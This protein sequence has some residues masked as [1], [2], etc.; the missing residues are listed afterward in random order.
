MKPR[1]F[2]SYRK[3]STLKKS[4]YLLVIATLLLSIFNPFV[5]LIENTHAASKNS[6][7]DILSSLSDE[8]RKA[9]RNLEATQNEGL[10]GFEPRDL[11]VEEDTTVIVEFQSK[12]E[13]ISRLT[14]ALKGVDI[15]TK[16][17]KEK[18]Q[19]E[20][21]EFE[22]YAKKNNIKIEKTYQ[23][24]F[25]G[26]AVTLPAD[27]IESLLE[28]DGVK[29]IY[30]NNTFSIE[31]EQENDQESYTPHMAD[32]IPFLSIDRL[33]EEGITGKGVK[34][35]VIDTGIDYH[36]P[37]LKD[38]F[39]GGYD[40]IDND[41]DPME[42]TYEDWKESG[43]PLVNNFNFYYT[44]HGTHVAGTIAA[45]GK[46]TGGVTVKGVA[47]DVQLYGYRVLGP[48][49]SG[50]S[51]DIIAGIDRAVSDGM[52]VIN[53]SL[54][55][56]VNEPFDPTSIAINNAVLSGVV[57][58]VS[59]GNTG[60]K[61]YSLGTP[62][63]AAYALTVG[64]SS[65]SLPIVYFTA[66]GEKDVS[67]ELQEYA[68]DFVTDL[69]SFENQSFDIVDLGNG[70]RSD[71][72]GKN[73]EGKV[74]LVNHGVIGTQDKIVYA[75]EHGAIAVLIYHND[76][77]I[78]EISSFAGE[79]HRFIPSFYMNNQ[80]GLE[81]KDLLHSGEAKLKFS[82]YTVSYTKE[83]ELAE[84]S[85]RGPSREN[86]DIK[87]EV[88]AP[89]VSILSTVPAYSV[90][91]AASSDYR[92]AYDRYS[93]TSMAAPHV[94]GM[95]ALMLQNNPDL[96][97]ADIKTLLMN[98]SVPLKG[99]YSVFDIGAGRIS[100]YEAIH[101]EVEL[102]VMDKTPMI[103]NG[104]KVELDEVTGSL[105]FGSYFPGEGNVRTQ[106]S[107]TIE[108]KGKKK[109]QFD[110]SVEFTESSLDAK[111]GVQVIVKDKVHVK[112][113][114]QTKTNVSLIVP[115][116]AEIGMYEGYITFEN[117]LDQEE[118]YRIPF[119]FRTMENGFHFTELSSP[120]ISPP[121]VHVK[122]NYYAK[123]WVDLQFS[124][125]SPMK[126][127]DFVL[128]EGNTGQDLGYLGSLNL[129]SAYDG[130]NYQVSNVFNGEYYPFTNEEEQPIASKTTKAKPG[131]Y[132]IKAIGTSKQDLVFTQEMNV[133]IDPKSPS[134]WSELD[135]NA[136]PVIEYPANQEEYTFAVKV[137]DS[138]IDQM[139]SAGMNVDQTLNT[140]NY[141][142]NNNYNP[143]IPVANDGSLNLN[144][145]LDVNKPFISYAIFA[146]D[147]ANN[148]SEKKTY[149]FIKEGMPYGYMDSDATTVNMGDT[150]T[151]TLVINNVED[152]VSGKWT[153]PN[154]AN[155]FDVVDV[156]P[157]AQLANDANPVVNSEI[158]G[159]NLNITLNADHPLSGELKAVDLQIKVKD[160]SFQVIGELKPTFTYTNNLDEVKTI[161]YAPQSINIVPIYSE[162]LGRLSSRGLG[163][164][165]DWTKMGATIDLRNEDGTEYDEAG[166]LNRFGNF[167]LSK[168]PITS[169]PF[170]L[171][172]SL[173]GHFTSHQSTGVGVQVDDEVLGQ[174]L[175][176]FTISLTP[177]D[178][179]QDDTID[180]FDA[181]LIKEN[182]N[183]T[184]RSADIN[185]D[186]TVDRKDLDLVVQNY[187]IQNP[188]AQDP[189]EPQTESEGVT[190]EDIL[191]ELGVN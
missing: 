159:N 126:K 90:F 42:T 94:A 84:F 60:S 128:T 31:P 65:T 102:K 133:F 188:D 113:N 58:V 146:S 3:R 64:A 85:S 154:F 111:K 110:V 22:D 63:A 150:F 117:K 100:P 41:D 83:D 88:T 108:N 112:S 47:P 17:A 177:G 176:L 25:N 99:E 167:T 15:S 9:L 36:H 73:V 123:T 160:S 43:R 82:N 24:A 34:V 30:K 164:G 23:T 122:R 129:E 55:M 38:A 166:S 57:A 138:E 137:H 124:F 44:S 7:V 103:D 97:P 39:A 174:Q 147:A 32:S 59:A 140:I 132:K 70:R 6:A 187:L 168:L 157:N 114:S 131:S 179:N 190:L 52:D 101:S 92:F 18:V 37:D 51:E 119:A 98:T 136:S 80:D 118:S 33:H 49:G 145:P 191:E 125:K 89:G 61:A 170:Q 76:P 74:V 40:I 27:K 67:I 53:L 141:S 163:F 155:Y 72:D 178:V 158:Q 54:G 182:W 121:Y 104:E 186:G 14:S 171:E 105:S 93:G 1:L 21:V 50:Q 5:R 153:I 19:E 165:I 16:E 45:Q 184:N 162:L 12:P 46:N 78:G 86:I 91:N 180:I 29:A 11:L 127:I 95:A 20:H 139:M 96:Q 26:M 152:L 69:R 120:A 87:P 71:Y 107:I 185:F 149:Y 189:P 144:V 151:T 134:L 28:I 66:T 62:G 115:K 183:S 109:K 48:Y 68:N 116:T 161:P 81:L 143:V 156:R 2:R 77:D 172:I 148:R 130:I 8:Q 142:I 181:L 13:E 35:G 169:E 4:T 10:L 135:E 79:D 173:P 56:N 106:R 75:K 175:D